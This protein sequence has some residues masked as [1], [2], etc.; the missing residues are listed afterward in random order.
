MKKKMIALLLA[1]AMVAAMGMPV[2]AEEAADGEA[3]AIAYLTPAV[4]FRSGDIWQ[5]VSRTKSSIPA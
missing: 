1:G 3:K 4:I 2:H 5:T